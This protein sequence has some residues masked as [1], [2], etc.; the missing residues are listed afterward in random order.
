MVDNI[1]L[2]LGSNKGDRIKFLLNAVE[3]IK[4]NTKCILVNSSSVYETTPYGNIEQENFFNA[5]INISSGLSPDELFYFTKQIE[6]DSGRTGLNKKWGPREIDVDILFYNQLIYVKDNLISL[7]AFNKTEIYNFKNSNLYSTETN[8]KPGAD[9]IAEESES[10]ENKSL[11]LKKKYFNGFSVLSDNDGICQSKTGEEITIEVPNRNELKVT[12]EIS[13]INNITLNFPANLACADLVGIDES[14]NLF[15]ETEKYLSEIP[16]KVERQVLIFSKSGNLKTT[17]ELPDIK[18]LYTLKDLQIDKDGNLYQLLSYQDKVQII[19]WD[20]AAYSTSAFI[21][22]SETFNSSIH[23]NDFVSTKEIE[24]N[25]SSLNKINTGVSRRDALR[26]ADTYTAHQY[27]CTSS[28]LAPNGATAVDNDIVQTPSWLVVGENARLPYKWGGFNTIAQFDNGLALGRYAGDINTSGVSGYAYGVD[29]SGFVSRCWKLTYHATTSSMPGITTQYTSWDS[30]KPGDAIHKVGHVRLFVKRNVNG[31]F[32]IIEAAGRNW[33]VSYWSYTTSDLSS[34]TP[35]YYNSMEDNYNS[36]VPVLLSVKSPS[37]NQIVMDWQCDSTNILGYKIYSSQDG[38]SWNLILDENTCTI[39]YANFTISNSE[40]YFRVSSIKNDSPDYSESYW[41]NVLGCQNNS[42]VKKALIVDGF[43]REIGSWQGINNSFVTKYGNAIQLS[44]VDF[45]SIKTSELQNGSFNLS[46]YDYVF[47]ILGD[48]STTD[49][50][51]NSIE[52]QLVKDYLENGGNLFISGSE[53]GWDLGNK[54]SDA[55]KSFYNNYFKASFVSDDAGVSSVAG[56]E[57]TV[58]DSCS[59]NIGQTYDEDYPDVITVNGGSTLCMKYSNNK[60]AGVQYSGYFND[61]TSIG[62]VIY[63]SFPLETTADDE[64]FNSV[65]T[66][67]INYFSS[68]SVN[69][70]DIDEPVSSFSLSQNYPNPFNPITKI[71]YTIPVE[72]LRA[73]SLQNVTL[74][75]Y[76]ILGNEVATLVNEEK[77]AGEYEVEF[78]G[79]NISNGI[80]FYDLRIGENRLS[81]KM[82]LIK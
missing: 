26:L 30:L 78:T 65:I 36:Q 75:V 35:R 77:P 48:E 11:L 58:L 25:N 31:S 29:C 21:Q 39:T 61:S 76:D 62:K 63:L 19:K 79:N 9:F 46:D 40:K 54:G 32:K 73:T 82:C 5:V 72:T 12:S 17:I 44:S 2:G 13:G 45:T 24:T 64:S 37:Q 56:V 6:V 8:L 51:F 4:S 41:S 67:V 1:F 22:Y 20:K 50:T 38:D 80:Y 14:G 60:G 59:F 74:K 71:K 66:Q 28:N 3:K 81:K 7:S 55:D 69:V 27:K 18:Y 34:Y 43:E 57:N 68:V 15:V 23:Y 16:L 49:E 33:D 10:S 52:Q 53:I 42:T 47:W 70:N